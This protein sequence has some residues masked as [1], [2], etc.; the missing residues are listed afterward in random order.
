MAIMRKIIDAASA[1]GAAL[2][3][4]VFPRTCVVC[5]TALVDRE[6]VM[7][8]GCLCELPRTR[9]HLMPF[10]TI[11]HRVG[12]KV[13]LDIAAGWFYYQRDSPY[14]QLIRRAKYDDRPALA[15]LLGR[16]YGAE[17]LADGF[18][19]TRYDL[20]LPVGMHPRKRMSRGYNQSY[21]IAL[22]LGDSLGLPVADN[23]VAI[24]G[25]KSQ[26]RHNADERHANISGSFGVVRPDQLRDRNII[27]VDDII[28]TGATVRDCG[29]ALLEEAEPAS[30][31]VLSIGVTRMAG[32]AN[33]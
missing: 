17:L 3:D 18:N 32:G 27:I 14:A 24:R 1:A 19:A 31:S 8:A 16:M 4:A 13:A 11:H 7:C 23:L 10:N 28:T 22:G 9:L 2:L 15:R 33:V 5:G 25:H 12:H 29:V 21:E 30:L 20:L 6:E 26:T